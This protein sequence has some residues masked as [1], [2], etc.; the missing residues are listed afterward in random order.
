[1]VFPTPGGWLVYSVEQKC[2]PVLYFVAI[3]FL[4]R[5]WKKKSF[6]DDF[7]GVKVA[8]DI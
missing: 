8:K 2:P 6:T 5:L 4:D 7:F 1:M 3:L